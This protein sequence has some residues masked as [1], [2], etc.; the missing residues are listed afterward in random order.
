MW[1]YPHHSRLQGTV[2]VDDVN[3]VSGLRTDTKLSHT[4]RNEMYRENRDIY[5]TN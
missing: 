1:L 2:G 5:F 4:V 3:Q